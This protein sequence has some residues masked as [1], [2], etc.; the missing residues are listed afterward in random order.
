MTA[1]TEE[2]IRED[3]EQDNFNFLVDEEKTDSQFN[4]VKIN[5]KLL[6][7]CTKQEFTAKEE[8]EYN[9]KYTIIHLGGFKLSIKRK[10]AGE[11][12]DKKQEERKVEAT[13]EAQQETTKEVSKIKKQIQ[14]LPKPSTMKVE[15]GAKGIKSQS[16]SLHRKKTF[17]A[18]KSK[19]E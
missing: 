5:L 3:I 1:S 14:K 12:T 18:K 16:H 4:I 19:S 9:Y 8:K 10:E 13:E 6:F 2:L 17:L 15:K 11:S 7:E